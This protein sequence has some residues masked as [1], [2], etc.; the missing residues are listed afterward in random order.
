L[1]STERQ[2]RPGKLRQTPLQGY[3]TSDHAHGVC[4]V[5]RREPVHFHLVSIKLQLV[6]YPLQGF[7]HSCSDLFR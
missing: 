1:L 4:A 3:D 5:S 6:N 2:A 7:P